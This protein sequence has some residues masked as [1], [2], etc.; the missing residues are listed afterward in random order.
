MQLAM[1][2]ASTSVVWAEGMRWACAVAGEV[3]APQRAPAR[4]TAR[5]RPALPADG[6]R[7]RQLVRT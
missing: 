2:H 5:R 6:L 1:N 4:D 3:Y 7:K